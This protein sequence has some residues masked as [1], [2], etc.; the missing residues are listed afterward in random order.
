M[1]TIA[2]NIQD[3]A[4]AGGYLI[5]EQPHRGNVRI[6]TAT[7]DADLIEKCNAA[8]SRKDTSDYEMDTV[9]GCLEWNAHDLR[10][11]TVLRFADITDEICAEVSCDGPRK[12]DM[13]EALLQ[14]DWAFVLS[15][16]EE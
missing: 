13:A 12:S 15:D 1:T 3:P 9:E 14:L 8:A 4:F 5:I 7:D 10:S 2:R 16:D 11:Q 6:W